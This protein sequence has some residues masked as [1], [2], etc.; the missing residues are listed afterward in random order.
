MF[1]EKVIKDIGTA[2]SAYEA[3]I[4]LAPVFKSVFKQLQGDNLRIAIFGAGGTGKTTLGN[5]LAGRAILNNVL[6]PYQESLKVEKF[7]LDGNIP[8]LTLNTA[9]SV[10]VAP[11]QEE[12]QNQW[13][14][15]FPKIIGGQVCLIINVVS[16]GYHSFGTL[17]Y[18]EDPRY[19]SGMTANQFTNIYVENRRIREIEALQA[20]ESS[21]KLAKGR[22][23]MMLTLVT[24]QDLWWPSRAK[25][26][27]YYQNGEYNQVVNNIQLKRGTDWFQHEY[28]SASLSIEN[29]VSGIEEFL[30]PNSEGYD[31][32]L[33]ISNIYKLF[34]IIS[35]LCDKSS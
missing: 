34:N 10:Q 25:V 13:D 33:K 18:Q 32:R 16:Y 26:Q 6:S 9:G 31:E 30:W 4:K 15:I 5:I 29:F 35:S 7:K 27:D 17:S 20:I 24:K 8:G 22:K 11:G 12:R 1:V 23:I 19:Q 21:I 14:E 2:A 3:S 28:A